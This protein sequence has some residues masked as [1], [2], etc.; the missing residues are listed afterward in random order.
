M[1]A[2]LKRNLRLGLRV[3]WSKWL[4]EV[5]SVVCLLIAEYGVAG[6]CRD[7]GENLGVTFLAMGLTYVIVG[8]VSVALQ[9]TVT[10]KPGAEVDTFLLELGMTPIPVLALVR[11]LDW[12][13]SVRRFVWNLRFAGCVLILSFFGTL[14]RVM[15]T[16]LPLARSAITLPLISNTVCMVVMCMLLYMRGE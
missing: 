12:C 13:D 8:L 7:H 2:F 9:T 6:Y 4:I 3:G 10:V 5:L 11:V 15:Y 16:R 14:D 1:R